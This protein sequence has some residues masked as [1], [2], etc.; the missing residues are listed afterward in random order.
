[1]KCSE[2]RHEEIVGL[3]GCCGDRLQR[4]LVNVTA[5]ADREDT[6]ARLLRQVSLRDCR[7]AF[8]GRRPIGDQDQQ[9][10]NDT[11]G[12]VTRREHPV[13]CGPQC[14]CDVGVAS[15]NVEVLYRVHRVI[16]I[17]VSIQFEA[18]FH[19]VAKLQ[20]ANLRTRTPNNF[21]LQTQKGLTPVFWT[22]KAGSNSHSSCSSC[23]WNQFSKNP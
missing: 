22:R 6:N 16:H 9:A 10:R 4:L 11:D 17:V 5:D 8:G 19:S 7:V 14:P 15:C 3:P 21:K 23:S 13:S 20:Q 1:M 12:A 2:V 18:D